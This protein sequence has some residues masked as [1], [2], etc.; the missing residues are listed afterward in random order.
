MSEL[1]PVKNCLD[2]RSKLRNDRLNDRNTNCRSGRGF[3]D[4]NMY[5]FHVR[6]GINYVHWYS[7][8]IIS[9]SVLDPEMAEIFELS[10]ENPAGNQA[11]QKLARSRKSTPVRTTIV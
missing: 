4:I 6:R 7:I 2:S 8:A 11:V 9:T 3:K 1:L 10:T 5:E